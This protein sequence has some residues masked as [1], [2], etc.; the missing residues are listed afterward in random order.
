MDSEKCSREAQGS[1]NLHNSSVSRMR[2][3]RGTKR[4]TQIGFTGRSR[5]CCITSHVSA[6]EVGYSVDQ[7]LSTLSIP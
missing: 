4:I 1:F 7:Q 2:Q 6:C 3:E 5:Q